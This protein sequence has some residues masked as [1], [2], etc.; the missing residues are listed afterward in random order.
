MKKVI[1]MATFALISMVSFA[2]QS[3]GTLL[4]RPKVGLNFADLTNMNTTPRVGVVLGAEAEY[5]LTDIV[6]VSAGALYSVQGARVKNIT[7]PAIPNNVNFR[8]ATANFNYLN[9]PFLANVYVMENL[10]VSLG[11]QPSICIAS[12]YENGP[13]EYKDAAKTLELSIPIGVSYT[14]GNLVFDGRYN[15]GITRAT[16]LLDSKN[17]VFQFTVGYNFA[18]E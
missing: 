11:L 3:V 10:N 13:W 1:L 2:Q 16:T 7:L 4:V 8:K 17:S 9:F 6:S 12:G 5:Q 18:L 15:F 14:T